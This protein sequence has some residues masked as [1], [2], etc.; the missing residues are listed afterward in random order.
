[1]ISWRS[2]RAISSLVAADH[3][4]QRLRAAAAIDR[5]HPH[6]GDVPAEERNP[7]QFALQDVERVAQIGKEGD[8]IPEGLVLRREDEGALRAGFPCR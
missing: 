6:L 2:L 7:H 3:R 4:L 1:M 8:R 5:D